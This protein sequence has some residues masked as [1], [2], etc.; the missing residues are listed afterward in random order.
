MKSDLEKIFKKTPNSI[1]FEDIK[2]QKKISFKEF[3]ERS[4]RIA[5]FLID[6]ENLRKGDKVIIR[7]NHSVIFYEFLIACAII[8]IVVCPISTSITSKRFRE[9]R[10]SNF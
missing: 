3:F 2:N 4:K 6:K 10:I 5:N 8:G 9:I 7:I 1:F